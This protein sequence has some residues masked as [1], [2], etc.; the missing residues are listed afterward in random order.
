MNTRRTNASDLRL[1]R[2][3]PC[4]APTIGAVDALLLGLAAVV[5]VLVGAAAALAI[6]VSER[7]QQHTDSDEVPQPLLP[8]GSAEVLA[9][10]RS[11]TVVLD[12]ED[13]VVRASPSAYAFGLVRE[14]RML[15][16]QLLELV[17]QVRRDG[18][19]RELELELPRGPIGSATQ[20]LLAG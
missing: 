2:G 17:R 5:G 15:S 12:S 20:T 1:R 16:P 7:E 14:Q 10:L 8:P 9:L 11:S 19:I 6:R 3:A 18:E 4:P 13:R